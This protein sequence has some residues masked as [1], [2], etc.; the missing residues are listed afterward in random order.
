MSFAPK[1]PVAA[2]ADAKVDAPAAAP[3][4]PMCNK[5]E[6]CPHAAKG[7]CKYGHELKDLL[8]KFDQLCK[9]PGC[10]R[11][12]TKV[13]ER[14]RWTD[15]QV[16]DPRDRPAP[17]RRERPARAESP[18]PAR[19]ERPA[20]TENPAP[21]HKQKPSTSTVPPPPTDLPEPPVGFTLVLRL[22]SGKWYTS[23]E[24]L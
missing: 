9:K 2:E 17:A 1:K 23:I 7:F 14:P 24:R 8:C 5:G 15:D 20:R 19:S 22:I 12:H 6:D 16:V 11:K 21:A 10:R 18:A 3:E 4:R 13:D